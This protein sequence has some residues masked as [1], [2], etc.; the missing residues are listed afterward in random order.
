[1]VESK[2]E[3][4]SRIETREQFF[5]FDMSSYPEKADTSPELWLRVREAL[6][7]AA[8]RYRGKYISSMIIDAEIW[9]A[10]GYG[11]GG[12]KQLLNPHLWVI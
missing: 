7:T 6:L 10:G 11:A 5:Y 8:D 9:G 3:N 1:M 12:M 2:Y 4:P